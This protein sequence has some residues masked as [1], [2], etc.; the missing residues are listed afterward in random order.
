MTVVLIGAPSTELRSVAAP[1]S[2]KYNTM[3][4]ISKLNYVQC[5]SS[6]LLS[7]LFYF[8]L[9]IVFGFISVMLLCWPIECVSCKI[10]IGCKCKSSD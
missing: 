10:V 7:V 2:I 6:Y 1:R 3:F 8:F 5:K 4:G 9:F